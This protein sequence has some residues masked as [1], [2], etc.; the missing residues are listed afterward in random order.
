MFLNFKSLNRLMFLQFSIFYKHKRNH[1]RKLIFIIQILGKFLLFRKKS[2][3]YWFL[4]CLYL[5]RIWIGNSKSAARHFF[6]IL[7]RQNRTVQLDLTCYHID[8]TKAWKSAP[9]SRNEK[10]EPVNIT[11]TENSLHKKVYILGGVI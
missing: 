9:S 11:L 7:V 5:G 4:W 6:S 8:K 1:Y 3:K 10:I 2:Q